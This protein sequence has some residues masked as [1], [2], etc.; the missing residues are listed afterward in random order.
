MRKR[1][2]FNKMIQK[3]KVLYDEVNSEVPFYVRTNMILVDGVDTK[4]KFLSIIQEILKTLQFAIYQYILG[5]N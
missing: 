2:E 5:R 4:K 3:Y 1:E